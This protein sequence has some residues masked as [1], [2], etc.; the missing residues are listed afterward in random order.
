MKLRGSV[1]L[2]GIAVIGMSLSSS[3]IAGNA[4]N[5]TAG[6]AQRSTSNEIEPP[7]TAASIAA[8]D[9]IYHKSCAGCHGE[10]AQGGAAYEGMPVAP[11]NLTAPNLRIAANDREMFN[12]IKQG[13]APD[14]YMMPFNGML[15]DAQIWN[16]VH[17][18]DSLRAKRPTQ[19]K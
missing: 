10:Q 17:Y 9:Q 8:G 5:D 18:I 3:T 11:P 14:Y 19:G 4:P 7:S 15:T 6:G 2:I 13:I 12:A 1:S 16:V